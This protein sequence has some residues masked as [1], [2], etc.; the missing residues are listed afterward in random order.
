MESLSASLQPYKDDLATLAS[1][2]TML[3]FVTGVLACKKIYEDNSTRNSSPI[4]FITS[5]VTYTN[6]FKDAGAQDLSVS[7]CRCVLMLIYSEILKD[8]LMFIINAVGGSLNGLYLLFYLCYSEDPYE[9]VIKPLFVG[10][11][12]MIAMY[13]YS[14][15]EDIQQVN[16]RFGFITTC[17][18]VALH[19][20]PL[21]KAVRS[22]TLKKLHASS[23]KKFDSAHSD[24]G[25]R[26]FH[27]KFT[28]GTNCCSSQCRL[29]AA[30][31]CGSEHV[32]DGKQIRKLLALV[33]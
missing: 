10:I 6:Y 26:C 9:E 11:A 20:M 16:W 5:I 32:C 17:I 14:L 28:N 25:Q 3:Q 27:N 4:P 21:L 15:Y 29:A 33:N 19:S 1:I 23:I 24:R 8:S 30:W 13:A 12:V 31:N 22:W 2:L 18:M 7:F